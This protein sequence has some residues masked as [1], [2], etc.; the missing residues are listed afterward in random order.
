MLALAGLGIAGA[1]VVAGAVWSG[2]YDI[3]A[4]VP[5]TRPVYALLEAARERSIEVRAARLELPADL[6]DAARVRQGAGNYAAM[7]SGCHG[8]PGQGETELQRGLYPRPPDLTRE[9]IDPREAFWVVKHGIKASGMPAWGRS[10]DDAYLWNLVA[11]VE[12]LPSLDAAGYEAAVA[13]SE[14]HSHGGGETHAHEHAQAPVPDAPA[15]AAT[16]PAPAGKVHVHADGSQHVHEA[17]APLDPDQ[18]HAVPEAH[19]HA[20]APAPVDAHEEGHEH[21][22]EQPHE[23]P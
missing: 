6:A 8:A 22:H 4:D 14:G 23:H 18:G 19:D 15:A 12:T 1:A 16:E 10:M 13:A 2:V 21:E 3:G 5:H 20:E 17:P 11:F 7:C 9:R